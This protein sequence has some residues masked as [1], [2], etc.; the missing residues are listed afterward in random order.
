MA[1]LQ[2]NVPQLKWLDYFN[3]LMDTEIT[4]DEPIVTY[5][6]TY[7]AE[8]GKILGET[9]RRYVNNHIIQEKVV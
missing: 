7:F 6:M 1:E 3:A 5:A 8:M 2:K 4:N 9:N